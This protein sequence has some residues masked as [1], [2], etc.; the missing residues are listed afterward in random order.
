MSKILNYKMVHKDEI[1]KIP[2]YMDQVT[3]YLDEVFSDLLKSEDEK[4]LTK[5]MINN[6]VKAGLID[7]PLKKKY[8]QDQIMQLMMIYLLK[9]T[10]QIQE[11]DQMMKTFEDKDK[12]YQ[13]FATYFDEYAGSLSS[14]ESDDKLE[15]IMRLFI[16]SSLQKKYAEMLLN[17]L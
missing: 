13:D 2:L 1:P 16:S 9:S 17:E 6:Y 3:G 14:F 15:T 4:T 11:I 12:M 10:A 5:T 8:N 7:S